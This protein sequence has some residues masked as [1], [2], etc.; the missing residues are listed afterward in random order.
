M[1]F[2][3]LK[4]RYVLANPATEKYLFTHLQKSLKSALAKPESTHY[5]INH[6]N[7]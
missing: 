7:E 1:Y 2:V 6:Q 5:K 3:S 4:K